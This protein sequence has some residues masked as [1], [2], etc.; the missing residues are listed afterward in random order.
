MAATL[1]AD[2]DFGQDRGWRMVRNGLQYLLWRTGPVTSNGVEACAFLDLDGTAE[3]ASLQMYCVPTI[4]ADRG[5]TT[6]SP[7]HGVTLN[8]CL[9]RPNARGTVRLA[10]ADANL[11]VFDASMMPNIV[12][13]NTNAAV[14][15]V[16][17]RAVALMTGEA[18]LQT[19]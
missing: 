9:L 2:G 14:L 12:S 18:S 5:N 8:A 4:Y 13:G 6:V 11:R 17:D 15:A 16:A 19:H 10:S 3:D 1:G 7:T